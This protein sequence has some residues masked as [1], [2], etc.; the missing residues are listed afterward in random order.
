MTRLLI[1]LVLLA[2]AIQQTVAQSHTDASAVFLDAN[3]N[4]AALGQKR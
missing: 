4:Q 3:G 1:F 2:A